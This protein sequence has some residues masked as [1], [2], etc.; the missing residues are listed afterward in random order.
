MSGIDSLVLDV[1]L[2]HCLLFCPCPFCEHDLYDLKHHVRQVDANS[3]DKVCATRGLHAKKFTCWRC[4]AYGT[5]DFGLKQHLRQPSPTTTLRTRVWEGLAKP[6]T[7]TSRQS[8]TCRTRLPIF[9]SPPCVDELDLPKTPRGVPEPA[10]PGGSAHERRHAC[11][12]A[13]ERHGPVP[14]VSQEAK[15]RQEAPSPSHPACPLAQPAFAPALLPNP[16]SFKACC[17]G[18]MHS[19]PTIK[20]GSLRTGRWTP[21]CALPQ[22]KLHAH[23]SATPAPVQASQQGSWQSTHGFS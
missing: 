15:G 6:F 19:G 1:A 20:Q 12:V 10:Q 17:T 7:R 4:A 8:S 21:S 3:S 13:R 5:S 2:S 23:A 16:Q 14:G 22:S 9:S 18:G 11:E